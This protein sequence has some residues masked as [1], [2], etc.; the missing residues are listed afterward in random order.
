L[1]RSTRENSA[2]L[3]TA[4]VLL[5]AGLAACAHG[6]RPLPVEEARRQVTEVE[7]AFARTMAD[8][9]LT[10]F[11]R[12][13]AEDAV[14]HSGKEPLRG[15]DAVIKAW[16][17]FFSS[18]EAPFSWQPEQVE[19]AAGGTLGSTSGPVYS[20]SGALTGR[21]SSIWQ[22]Q[23]GGEWRIVFDSGSDQ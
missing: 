19:V 18:P 5:L 11:S 10:A 9:D 6:P 1:T 2:L 23:P 3:R 15:R 12:F 13:I 16:T 20:S 4:P 17:P 14:F 22:R 8:R 7:R 21:F